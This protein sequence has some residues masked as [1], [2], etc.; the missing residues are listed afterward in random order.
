MRDL[1]LAPTGGKWGSIGRLKDQTRRLF[2]STVSAS[3][4]DAS[5]TYDTGYRFAD[6]TMILWDA[7]SPDQAGLWK[8]TVTLTDSFYREITEHPV[9]I[10]MRAINAL[11]RSPMALDV[12]SW[13]TYRN[14]YAK[15]AS[16]IPWGLLAGQF[17]SEYAQARQ[18]K[19]AFLDALK[20]VG[21]VYEGARFEVTDSGLIVKPSPTHIAKK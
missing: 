9:P 16:T 3:Y 19:A 2:A 13:L 4:E 8:S 17:G 10:D 5:K 14:S 18:F 15:K 6:A 7:K 12:Y 1:G 11:K 20:K 21:L